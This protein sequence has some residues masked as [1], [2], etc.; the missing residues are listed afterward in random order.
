[1]FAY[2]ATETIYTHTISLM[3]GENSCAAAPYIGAVV[4]KIVQRLPWEHIPNAIINFVWALPT[5][6]IVYSLCTAG[7]IDIKSE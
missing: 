2:V 6:T 4:L 1:M 3:A 5:P 7:I